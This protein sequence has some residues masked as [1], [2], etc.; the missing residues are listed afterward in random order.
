MG[1]GKTSIK[2]R[3]AEVGIE[4][5]MLGCVTSIGGFLFG[6]LDCRHAQVSIAHI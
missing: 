2:L 3:G 4:A 6:T 1:L 5:I